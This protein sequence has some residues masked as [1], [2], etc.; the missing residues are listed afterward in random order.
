MDRGENV[1]TLSFDSHVDTETTR[2]AARSATTAEA[3][4]TTAKKVADHGQIARVY[5]FTDA[6]T[7][8]KE[9]L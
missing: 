3:T 6:S 7:L 4:A 9:F 2:T 5:A 8:G 1:L